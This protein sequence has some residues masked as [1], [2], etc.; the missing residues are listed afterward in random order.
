M[1][2]FTAEFY[3]TLTKKLAL[4]VLKLYHEIEREGAL[5]NLFYEA[6]ISLIPKPHKDRIRKA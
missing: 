6:G 3:Q 4:K 5:P 2:R 1:D